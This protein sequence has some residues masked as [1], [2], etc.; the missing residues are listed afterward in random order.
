MAREDK[1][2]RALFER[3][4]L[5][6]VRTELQNGLPKTLLPVRSYALRPKA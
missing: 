4:G 3:A 6:I 2:F 1:K 5:V